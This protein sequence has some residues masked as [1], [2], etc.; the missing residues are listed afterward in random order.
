MASFLSGKPW[1]VSADDVKR[2]WG[3]MGL[4]CPLCG[5][6]FKAG[7][8]ARFVFANGTKAAQCGNFFTCD[9]CDGE[10]VFQRAI[11]DFNAAREGAIRWGIYGPDW[12]ADYDRALAREGRG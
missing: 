6:K 9:A 7:D 10:D 11:D 5:R 1:M 2:K 3:G 12:Q 4:K 8:V